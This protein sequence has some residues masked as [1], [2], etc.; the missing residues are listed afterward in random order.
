[1]RTRKGGR[2]GGEEEGHLHDD[3][4][5]LRSV[6]DDLSERCG[7]ELR[8]AEVHLG[9]E[10]KSECSESEQSRGRGGKVLHAVGPGAHGGRAHDGADLVYF[11]SLRGAG[12]QRP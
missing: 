8:E 6:G 5:L 12:E 11:V 10:S 1:M 7:D 2:G 9:S 4:S 3:D